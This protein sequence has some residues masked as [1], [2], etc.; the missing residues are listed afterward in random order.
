MLSSHRKLY[1]QIPTLHVHPCSVLPSHGVAPGDVLFAPE[2][3]FIPFSVSMSLS[4]FSRFAS[5]IRL[6]IFFRAVED[7][8]AGGSVDVEAPFF[9][10]D[11]EPTDVTS[12]SEANGVLVLSGLSG[13]GRTKQ[14]NKLGAQSA[15]E[16]AK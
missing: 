6:S 5:F 13:W 3:M 10:V 14:G 11:A 8:P 4:P 1:K 12:R 9:G 7:V 15:G 2:R 16:Q